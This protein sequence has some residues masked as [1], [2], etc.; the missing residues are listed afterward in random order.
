MAGPRVTKK[1]LAAGAF[2]QPVV[3]KHN[4]YYGDWN[5]NSKLTGH[6]ALQERVFFDILSQMGFPL[7]VREYFFHPVRQWRFDYCWINEKIV[8]EVE[9]G[10]TTFNK[11]R[12]QQNEGY[13][14]DMAKYNAATLMGYRV[15]RYTWA[16]LIRQQIIDDLAAVFKL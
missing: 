2:G 9:G 14:E 11:S 13:Q 3:E 12:H 5:P 15:L 16:Q 1:Q 8:V 10:V 6:L 7:P 4:K